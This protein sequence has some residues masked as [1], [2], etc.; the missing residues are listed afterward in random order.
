[1]TRWPLYQAERSLTHGQQQHNERQNCRKSGY[2][3]AIASHQ[4]LLSQQ[5]SSYTQNPA[6]NGILSHAQTCA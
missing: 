5:D 3:D 4:K 6:G 2:S 1:M